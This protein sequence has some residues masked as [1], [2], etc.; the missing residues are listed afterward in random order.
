MQTSESMTGDINFTQKEAKAQ[1]K[2]QATTAKES[3]AQAKAQ[4]KEAK[5]QAKAQAKEQATAAK[6]SKAQAKA[7]AK[8]AKAQAKA[9]AKAAKE[10]EK[11]KNKF[12]KMRRILN[13]SLCKEIRY[14]HINSFKAKF[15][16]PG[17]EQQVAWTQKKTCK[18]CGESK[19]LMVFKANDCGTGYIILSD[20]R[21]SRRPDC[22][23]CVSKA[24]AGKKNAEAFAKAPEGTLCRLCSKPATKSNPMVYDHHH[25]LE[26]FRGYCCNRCNIGMGTLGDNVSSLAKVIKYMNETEGLSKE[27]LIPMIFD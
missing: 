5:A 27:Q 22:K 11:S 3:K 14:Y 19:S 25:D 18:K 16:C 2:E 1:P 23:V 10:A 21:R 6:E 15:K 4:A 26:V 7:Q 24:E 13:N 12:Q 9:Q 20:N 17:A 8:E